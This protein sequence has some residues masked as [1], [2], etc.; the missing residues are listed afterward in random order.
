MTAYISRTAPRWGPDSSAAVRIC[1]G[2]SSHGVICSP[3]EIAA[4]RSRFGA[5]VKLVVPGIRPAGQL[6][7]IQPYRAAFRP[8]QHCLQPGFGNGVRGL[9]FARFGW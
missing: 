9:L 5:G 2:S 8:A 7:H 3:Q 4:L 1:V 6:G